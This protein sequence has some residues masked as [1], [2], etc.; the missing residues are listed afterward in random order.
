MSGA[1]Q[2]R[3]ALVEHLKELHLPA[4]RACFEEA[5]RRAEKETLSYEQY[6]LE[7]SRAGVRRPAAKSHRKLLQES[8]LPLEKS[9]ANFDLKRLP[10]KVSRQMK[11]LLEGAFWTA[12]RTCW[13]SGIPA[14]GKATCC[15]PSRRN[16]SR[17]KAG[18]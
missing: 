2:M 5:A 6:L 17:R 11:V 10:A 9:L 14:R 3:T 8:E 15:A 4:M 16:W 7:L 18:R 12:R 1:T 13:S